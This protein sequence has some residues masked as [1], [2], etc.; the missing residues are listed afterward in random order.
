MAIGVELTIRFSKEE[1][2]GNLDK[3]SFMELDWGPHQEVRTVPM[4][5]SFV[6][7]YE[8]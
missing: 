1:V 8:E 4:G 6:E 5:N 7:F 2:I 3:N